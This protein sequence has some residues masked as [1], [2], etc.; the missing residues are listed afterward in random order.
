MNS[1]QVP[2]GIYLPH[3][4]IPDQRGFAPAIV[5]WEHARRMRHFEP[6][7]FCARENREH[8]LDESL[9]IS[10]FAESGLY[11]L[12][13]RKWTRLD[14]WPLHRRAARLAQRRKPRLWHAHQLEFPIDDF[15]AALGQPIPVLVHA[16]VTCHRFRPEKGIANRYLA[17]SRYVRERLVER[18]GYPADL[19]E[20]LPNGVDVSLF[21]PA[22]GDEKRVLRQALG[23]PRDVLLILFAGRKQL[24]KGF[25]VFLA[26]A[27]ALSARFPDVY[28]LAVGPEP[29]DAL[30]EIGYRERIQ[31]RKKLLAAGRYQER[32]AMSQRELARFFRAADVLFAPSRTETQGM[33]VIE[34]MASGLVVIS[35]AVGGI[36]ESIRHEK[37]GFLLTSPG[38][39][40]EAVSRMETV[41]DQITS[42]DDMRMAARSTTVEQFGWDAIVEQLENIYRQVLTAEG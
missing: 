26:V 40:D 30:R 27:E 1:G 20:I 28:W 15:R 18:Q 8:S 33:V 3:G 36:T 35:N 38:N 42:L 41:F 14:P 25:D 4:D 10:R 31:L 29:P 19:I 16:H 39:V 17:V 7:L 6:L 9:P 5:A 32:P 11:R 21:C 23:L 24:V 22:D 34:G 37:N 2:V 13:F 12:F